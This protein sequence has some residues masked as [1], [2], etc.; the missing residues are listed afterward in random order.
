MS[1]WKRLFGGGA[2]EAP[3]VAASEN[4]KGFV[5]EARPYQDNGQWQLAGAIRRESHPG[6]EHAFIRADRFTDAET[7]ARFALIKG[8][9]IIDE[10]GKR[11]FADDQG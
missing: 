10:Q 9:Q 4:Y 8:R 6:S 2:N 7:A 5:I 3:K 1:F 11:L